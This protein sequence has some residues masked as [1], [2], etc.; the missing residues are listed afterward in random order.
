M[1]KA[2]MRCPLRIIL[3]LRPPPPPPAAESCSECRECAR[4]SL[5]LPPGPNRY[6]TPSGPYYPTRPLSYQ[7]WFRDCT[8]RPSEEAVVAGSGLGR[9]LV[10]IMGTVLIC[11]W[12]ISLPTTCADY[13]PV[14]VRLLVLPT[15]TFYGGLTW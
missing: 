9:S 13:P 8:I 3:K 12:Y 1:A 15:I 5:P 7:M 4:R 14:A 11:C 2:G 6:P 10:S